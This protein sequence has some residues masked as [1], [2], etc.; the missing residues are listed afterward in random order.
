ML[1]YLFSQA[2]IPQ[3]SSPRPRTVQ[4]ELRESPIVRRSRY[5]GIT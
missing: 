3:Q 1:Y 5:Q 4:P 2:C